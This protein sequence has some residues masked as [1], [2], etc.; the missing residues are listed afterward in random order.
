MQVFPL[1]QKEKVTNLN[2]VKGHGNVVAIREGGGYSEEV[3][4][5]CAVLRGDGF[6]RPVHVFEEAT[7]RFHHVQRGRHSHGRGYGL[8]ATTAGAETPI[9]KQQKKLLSSLEQRHSNYMAITI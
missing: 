3:S 5:S 8:S 2:H 9:T 6:D 1:N 7:I 4:E